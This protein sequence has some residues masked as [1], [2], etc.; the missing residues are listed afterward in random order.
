[1]SKSE[2]YKIGEIDLPESELPS[3]EEVKQA[4]DLMD[5]EFNIIRETKDDPV[6]GGELEYREKAR[7]TYLGDSHDDL[8]FCHF[9]Y[10]G[11]TENSIV[12]R[13]EDGEE[14]ERNQ[15][16]LVRPRVFY[17]ENGMFAFESRQDLVEQW[18]PTFIGKITD[19]DAVGNFHI[20]SF[21][22]KMMKDFYDSRDKITVFKFSSP[23]DKKFDGS[24]LLAEALNELANKVE[25]HQF[26]GGNEG[27]NLK[28]MTLVDE[29]A[30]KM[31]IEKLHGC[32]ENSLTMNILQSGVYVV[33][34]SESDWG[35]PI[36]TG[37]RAEAIFNR[38]APQIR[39]LS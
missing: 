29:A 16:E 17:F 19:T 26:S 6:S 12:V 4:I 18:I 22:Q 24:T 11:D 31:F 14:E 34:W 10:V 38:L 3:I 27:K 25:T 7:T 21:S 35:E 37:T 23:E 36:E 20:Y 13:N 33:T 39:R 5:D 1:M 15:P 2:R 28:G 30:D 8:S 32:N 9:I